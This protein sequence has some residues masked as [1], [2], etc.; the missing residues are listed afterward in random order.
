[1]K[2]H[3]K[4]ADAHTHPSSALTERFKVSVEGINMYKLVLANNR[5]GLEE[6]LFRP[7][8]ENY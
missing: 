8:Q 5:E 3:G 1:M 4:M 7:K 2:V 6:L